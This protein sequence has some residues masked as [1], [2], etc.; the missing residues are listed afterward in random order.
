MPAVQEEYGVTTLVPGNAYALAEFPCPA[1][2]S[3]AFEM[4][5]VQ[6]SQQQQQQQ[7]GQGDEEE[8]RLR[9]FQDYNPCPIGLFINIS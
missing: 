8:T 9:Y 4:T 2:E 1:G 3:A 6:Q 7:Q 5:A